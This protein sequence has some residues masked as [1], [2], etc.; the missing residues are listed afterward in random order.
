MFK[1]HDTLFCHIVSY[2]VIDFYVLILDLSLL[3]DSFESMTSLHAISGIVFISI[4]NCI[5]FSFFS[6]SL[7][8]LH[9]PVKL[10]EFF[11]LTDI[12]Q[13]F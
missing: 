5:F 9:L 12:I 11:I 2:F 7:N 4:R 3:F 10:V 1:M 6:R 13:D 8:H